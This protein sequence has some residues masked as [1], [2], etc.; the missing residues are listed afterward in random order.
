MKSTGLACALLGMVV[1]APD[2]AAAQAPET[3]QLKCDV[4]PVTKTYAKT[5]WLVYSCDDSRSLV[6]VAAPGNPA[7]P[8]YFM[9]S[10]NDAGYQLDAEGTGQ[11]DIASAAAEEIRKLSASDIAALIRETTSR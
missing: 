4:G 1:L 3:R 10:P 5:Q 2:P 6:I 11:K 8:F 9:M 7:A